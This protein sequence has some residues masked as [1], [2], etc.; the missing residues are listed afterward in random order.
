MVA[1]EAEGATQLAI[2]TGLDMAAGMVVDALAVGDEDLVLAPPGDTGAHVRLAVLAGAVSSGLIRSVRGVR[3][4]ATE[5]RGN[6]MRRT[7]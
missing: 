3:I 2:A 6:L 1:K 7:W 5:E 4:F